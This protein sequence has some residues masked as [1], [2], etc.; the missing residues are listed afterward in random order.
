MPIN[1]NLPEK[2]FPMKLRFGH[3]VDL[4][5]V[6]SVAALNIKLIDFTSRSNVLRYLSPFAL[7]TWED[8]PR[9]IDSYT[10]EEREQAIEDLFNFKLLP[11]A[12]ETIRFTF[13]ISNMDLID[14]THLIRHRTFTFSAHCTGDRDQ[15]E[16]TVLKKP[17]IMVNKEFSKRYDI[18]MNEAA[19]LYADMVDSREV[20]IL[21]ARTVLPRSFANHYY[22]SAS[23]KDLI[24]FFKQRLDRQIQPESDN[25]IALNM[26]VRVAAMYPEIGNIIRLDEPDHYYIKT[27]QTDH[28]SNL[29][30][31]EEKNDTF[32]WN[33]QWFIYDKE[34][35]KMPGASEFNSQWKCLSD[36]YN[37]T[38]GHV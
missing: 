7:A 18:L 12:M 2:D 6:N 15:R 33:P 8:S 29:F 35:S 5:I 31:P 20:S 10:N 14:V 37:K 9:C 24:P 4:D 32:E 38:V 27:A 25:L 23:L 3:P 11:G 30:R 36:L 1:K 19:D 26:L 34:R 22:A 13:L 28:S 17:S 21:D 16:D